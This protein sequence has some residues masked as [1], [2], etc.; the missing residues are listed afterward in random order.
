MKKKK[1]KYSAKAIIISFFVLLFAGAVVA[2]CLPLRPSYSEN[3]K[4]ELA[5]FPSFSMEA[6]LDGSYFSDI[7]TWYADTFPMRES[8]I[9]LNAKIKSYY[10]IG[11]SINGM[12]DIVQEEIPSIGERP[13][14]E[15]DAETTTEAETTETTTEE[16]IDESLIQKLGAVAIVK[17][18]GYEY[19]S[20]VK[21]IADD[22]AAVVNRAATS[23]KGKARVYDMVVPTSIDIMLGESVRKS[24]NTSDQKK[25]ISYIYSK[26]NTSV[27][28]VE[29]FD[30]LKAHNNEYIYFRTDHHWTALG[31]YYAYCEY[32]KT[33]GIKTA[34]LTDFEERQY[35]NFVG[36]FYN[37][38]GKKPVLEKNPDVVYA[39]AP[40]GDVTM[41]YTDRNG[42]KIEWPV[43]YNVSTWNRGT[44]YNTFIAGDQPY[45]VIK[46]KAIT[47]GSSV[48]VV[49]ESFGNALVPF[50]T[51]NY[52]TVH[53]ID[54]RVW[55]GSVAKF[56]AD[57]GIQD[58]VFINNISATR[59]RT[60]V[61]KMSN[62]V[63]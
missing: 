16:K 4:R 9:E 11:D 37:D 47:D 48:L 19:Y 41:T 5:K 6:L 45:C 39:Y 10:G 55:D 61:N 26:L 63:K 17:D 34:S 2:L 14:D 54:Y 43:I 27:N 15:P 33:A 18:S 53:V 7:S 36:T 50:L 31:A 44:K 56:V 60:L 29:T 38:S 12:N 42:N 32:T 13:N 3:E 8:L 20:F 40:K 58:V 21:S 35:D 51:E 62:I 57:N 46:N 1:L 23:L 52:G 30:T 59:N 22:Y 28:V 25:A 24:L 49:K